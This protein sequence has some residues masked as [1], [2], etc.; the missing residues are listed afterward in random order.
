MIFIPEKFR[1]H[2]PV[3]VNG[4]LFQ[5]GWWVCV[6]SHSIIL[7][8]A[9]T[10][11]F[12]FAHLTFFS[13][14]EWVLVARITVIGWALDSVMAFSE[15]LSLSGPTNVLPVWLL[16]I[17]VMFA[18]SPMLSLRFLNKNLWVAAVFGSIGGS[19]TYIAGARF[20]DDIAL[21]APD[22]PAWQAAATIGITWL[23]FLPLLYAYLRFQNGFRLACDR[24]TDA[25]NAT[26]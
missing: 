14:R 4:L 12:L 5:V 24:D 6:L 18:T 7:P 3:I 22:W 10:L 17:W 23:I 20:R 19:L 21:G 11:L 2:T 26:M 25:S 9:Y 15:V 16:C 13:A 8:I 1:Q